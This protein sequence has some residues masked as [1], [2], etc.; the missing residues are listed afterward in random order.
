[1]PENSSQLFISCVSDDFEKQTARFP[2]FRS[3]LA[4]YLRRADCTV[5]VQEDFRQSADVNTVG[6]LAGYVKDCRAVVHLLGK[7]P[8]SVANETARKAMQ[9][10]IVGSL[11]GEVGSWKVDAKAELAEAR[12]LIE[13]HNYNRRLPELRD[14]ESLIL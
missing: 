7:L 11:K 8:G 10:R 3:A 4:G 2:G 5:K 6:K 13:N 14:A 9:A 12:R 1:M